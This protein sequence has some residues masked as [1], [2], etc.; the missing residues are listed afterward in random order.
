MEALVNELRS[1]FVDEHRL[2][3]APR[4]ALVFVMERKTTL[5]A[6]CGNSR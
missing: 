6:A 4:M 5:T 1:Q 2:T 3:S